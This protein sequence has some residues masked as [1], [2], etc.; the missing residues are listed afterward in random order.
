MKKAVAIMLF[1]MAVG[2]TGYAQKQVAISEQLW[3]GYIQQTRLTNRWG[4]WMDAN[5]RTKDNWV[6]GYSVGF[7]RPGVTYFVSESAGF[8]VGYTYGHFFPGNDDRTI[9][10]PEHRPWQQFQWSTAYPKLRVQQRVRLEERFRRKMDGTDKLAEGY[11][12]NYRLRYNF[13]LSVPLRKN[14]TAPQKTAFV[15]NNEVMLNFGKEVISNT[16]D[17]NRIF[18]GFNYQLSKNSALQLGY[19]NTFQQQGGNRYRSIH[20][21]RLNFLQNFDLRKQSPTTKT[22][23]KL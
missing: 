21:L 11:N 9:A 23:Q 4:I 22:E 13:S 20:T 2:E 3:L 6:H 14:G 12:F 1:F 18:G 10:L 5:I 19:M 15:F 16:F 7:L 8:T 17:Q